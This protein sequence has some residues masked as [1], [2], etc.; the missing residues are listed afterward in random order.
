MVRF[1]LQVWQSRATFVFVLRLVSMQHW[2]LDFLCSTNFSSAIQNCMLSGLPEA[3][4][5]LDRQVLA[6]FREQ[7][8]S[9]IYLQVKDS[10]LFCWRV[11]CLCFFWD[12]VAAVTQRDNDARPAAG[13]LVAPERAK[14]VVFEMNV[15]V[16]IILPS[17]RE[18]C[19]RILPAA[20]ATAVPERGAT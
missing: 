11:F 18:P 5:P 7:R 13:A 15:S 10:T 19:Q 1:L 14:T 20:G 16:M 2:R 17:Q 4:H 9:D 8:P 12:H 6:A 3:P